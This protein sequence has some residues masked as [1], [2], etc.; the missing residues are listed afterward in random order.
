M[1]G[2]VVFVVLG[3]GLVAAVAAAVIGWV[4]E[5]KRREALAELA[6]NQGWQYFP[7]KNHAAARHYAFVNRLK[8]GD[9]RYLRHRFSGSRGGED[10]DAFEYHYQVTRGSGKNRR[11]THYYFRVAALRLP[12]R[13][14]ELT[15]E[16]EGIMD[17]VAAALGFD[18]IDFESAEFSRKF[19]VL[20]PDKKFAY[21]VIHPRMMEVLMRRPGTLM[22]IEGDSLVVM[23]S[24]R[25]DAAALAP[26]LDH[27]VELR[28]GLPAYLW[29]GGGA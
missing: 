13:F 19:R 14:A 1:D 5:K 9:N 23:E 10:F 12:R 29:E 22:E 4:N 17:K 2:A 28:R 27:L 7:E 6:R 25:M 11:T 18:D 20:S 3:L 15:V 21:D 26:L 24:G 8:R 16:P